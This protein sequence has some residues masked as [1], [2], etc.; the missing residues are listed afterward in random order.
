M[1]Y[2]MAA[3]FVCIMVALSGL[4]LFT[5]EESVAE[6]INLKFSSPWPPAHPQHTMVIEPWAKKIRAHKRASENNPVSR[7]GTGRQ[8]TIMI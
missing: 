2:K 3:F 4:S 5:A 7:R 1:M 8:R 6:T